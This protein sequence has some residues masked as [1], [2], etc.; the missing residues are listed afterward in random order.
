MN[1]RRVENCDRIK[2][3]TVR[4]AVGEDNVGKPWNQY[5]EDL[6]N[7]DTEEHLMLSVCGFDNTRMG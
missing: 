7:V 6:Y 5:F 4:L 2:A 1:G 3:K